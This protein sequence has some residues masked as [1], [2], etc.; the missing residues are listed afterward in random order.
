L[1]LQGTGTGTELFIMNST[2]GR[3][4]G[5]N[6]GRIT[7]GGT[8]QLYTGISSALASKYGLALDGMGRLI[9]E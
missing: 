1:G 4:S 5:G 9:V 8:F 7:A 2:G 3:E 6:I